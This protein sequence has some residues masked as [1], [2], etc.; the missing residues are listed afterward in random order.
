MY[1]SIYCPIHTTFICHGVCRSIGRSVEFMLLVLFLG[2][3]PVLVRVL[4]FLSES[5]YMLL[6]IIH[7]EHDRQRRTSYVD[8]G[9]IDTDTPLHH[10]LP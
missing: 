9:H 1:F 10:E 3:T 6:E 7:L 4:L 5:F 8:T 2:I